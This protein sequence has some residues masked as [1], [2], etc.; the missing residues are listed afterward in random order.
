[1]FYPQLLS[2]CTVPPSLNSIDILPVLSELSESDAPVIIVEA[3]L[4]PPV[5]MEGQSCLYVLHIS[6]RSAASATS[7][8]TTDMFYV[9]ETESLSL[10]VSQHRAAWKV[11]ARNKIL[12]YYYSILHRI[13]LIFWD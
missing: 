13:Y 2:L 3:Q 6:N 12:N 7:V 8:A 4:M 11:F 1:M 5:S 9:G 10:R